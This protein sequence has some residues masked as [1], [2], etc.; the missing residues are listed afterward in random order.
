MRGLARHSTGRLPAGGSTCARPPIG[1]TGP[2]LPSASRGSRRSSTASPPTWTNSPAPGGPGTWTPRRCY[3][4]GGRG[5]PPAG[6]AGPGV[7]GLLRPQGKA[8]VSCL[9]SRDIQL[10]A[11]DHDELLATARESL[12]LLARLLASLLTSARLQA[13]ALPVFPRSADLREISRAPS[14]ASGRRHARSWCASRPACPRSW[15]IRRS[16]NGSSRT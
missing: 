15:P 5:P 2:S 12:D 4:A 7:P 13:G 11:E 9:R 14:A 10:S 1:Q 8:A 3:P 6:R 16:W